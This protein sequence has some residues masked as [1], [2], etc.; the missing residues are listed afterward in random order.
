MMVGALGRRFGR[1]KKFTMVFQE[2]RVL[3]VR[4][5]A[6]IGKL[7]DAKGIEIQ[8]YTQTS[9]SSVIKTCSI[10]LIL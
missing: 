8:L 4:S 5:L 1:K 2:D 3:F 9:W 6:S 10:S 7:Y